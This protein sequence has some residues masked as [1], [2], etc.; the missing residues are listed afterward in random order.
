[1]N[2]GHIGT[3]VILIVILIVMIDRSQRSWWG[4]VILIDILTDILF[5]TGH[6]VKMCQKQPKSRKVVSFGLL[7]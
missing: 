7:Y 2:S 4:S 3:D 1:M 5:L 6:H